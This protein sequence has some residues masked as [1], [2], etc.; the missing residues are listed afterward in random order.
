MKAIAV[1]PGKA[2]SIHL[3]NVPKPAVDQ[4]PDGRGVL[5]RVL[6][7][8][9]DG[10][11]KEIN[12]AEYGAAP[13][14]DDFLII[15][16]ENFGVVEE[17]GPNVPDII[18]PGGYVV[19]SVRR[20]GSSIY[21]KI[22]L[23]DFTT[24]D[25]YYERGINLL[26]GYLTEYYVEDS[27]FVFPLPANLRDVGVL[28]EPTTVAEKGINHAYEIQRRLKVWEPRRACILGSGTI[29]LLMALAAR[30]RGLE[31]TVFSLPERPYRNADLV[32]ELGG[33]YFSSQERSLA[34]VSAERGPFDLMM[35]A[36][37]FSPLVW[38]AAEVLGKNGVL[39][40][41]S[42]TGGDP[43]GRDPVGRDQPELRARQQ[44]HGR[45]RQ[46]LAGRLSQRRRRSDQGR[47]AV[48]GLAGAA[49]DDADPGPR[50]VRPDDPGPH[51]RPRR[52]QG[53]R[54]GEWFVSVEIY[55]P[56]SDYALIS[57]CHSG[58]LVSKD[59]SVDWCTF[60]RFEA[61]PV[62]GRIL[63]WAKAGLFRIAPL[64]DD[65]EATRRYLPGTNVLETTFRT[66]TG[67]L[68]L[69]DFFAFRESGVGESHPDDQLIRIARCT[70]GDALVLQ[71]EL[72]FGH[73][74]LSATQGNR[75]LRAGEEAFV[76]LTY[77]LPHE[78][79]PR[80]LTR[81]EVHAK[82]EAT[83]AT[84]AAWADRC[85]YEGPYREQVV[86]SALVLKG[87]TNGPTGAIVAAA[88]TSLPEEVG[89]ERNW[90]YR[91]S[92]L[93]D[94]ALTLN[95]L[96]ATGYTDEANAY[97]EWLRRTTAG[98]ASELQIMYGVGGER[99]L[100]EVELDWLEGYR[101]S[102]PVRI[103]N[104]A[105]QQFQLDTFGERL[106]TA[107]PYRRHGGEIDG[108]S[109]DFLSQVGGVW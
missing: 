98:R 23:Q 85:T 53:L 15:G 9:V 26:H 62:F 88:T 83:S 106:G 45:H 34:E 22:G 60:H 37:G 48:P 92:W 30:L 84:W 97:M 63:D 77:Q 100:P 73:A 19:A 43:A 94:S 105:A 40:L 89:G 107:W 25:V 90:D 101:G 72:P 75:T 20:P 108:T 99:L 68:V 50:A 24:D 31:L 103:G 29:G 21:G 82:L 17:V 47:G 69:T 64:D 95:A 4:V 59:G 70:E 8:G 71:S 14:G 79:A 56:I 32:E 49:A 109:C 61:R 65:Y 3:V 12:A 28:L 13:E 33:V 86:R 51:R 67:T 38:E 81:D 55:P 46:R 104:G 6:R 41:S 7:V 1:H 52:D 36:T 80:R 78:L 35:D 18:R 5:V 2:G 16:H 44:G 57:D 91:F 54:G 96:F 58:A 10:T 11:D 93:R 87:L 27:N 102:R 42:I 74:E 66:P 76:V 39:V